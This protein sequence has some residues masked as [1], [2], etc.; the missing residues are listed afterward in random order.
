MFCELDNTS[1]I[2]L[3]IYKAGLPGIHIETM[4]PQYFQ[5]SL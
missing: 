2:I 5:F 4:F 3:H 1:S